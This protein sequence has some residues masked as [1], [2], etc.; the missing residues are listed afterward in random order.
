MRYAMI[1]GLGKW[2]QNGQGN[3]LRKIRNIKLDK[4]QLVAYR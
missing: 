3:P 1:F 4:L 2:L